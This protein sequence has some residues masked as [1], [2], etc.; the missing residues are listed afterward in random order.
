MKKKL[1]I[2]LM[3]AVCIFSLTACKSSKI[4]INDYLIEERNNLFTSQ[5][6]IY[7]ATLSTGLR[8]ENYNL[9]GIVNNKVEFGILTLTRLDNQPLANDNYSFMIK[10]NENTYTGMLEKSEVDNSYSADIEAIAPNDATVNVEITFTGYNYSQNLTN[11]SNE[12]TVDKSTAISLAND[13][14]KDELKNVTKDKNNKIEVVMKILKDYSNS[15]IK[16]YYWYVGVISTQGDT[17]GVLISADTGEIIA[18]KV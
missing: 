17:L 3:L 1:I 15:E 14:L 11:S 9:D 18:K 7:S 5:D 10:I 12:F 8:E 16:T 13:S 2:F 4:D 6:N